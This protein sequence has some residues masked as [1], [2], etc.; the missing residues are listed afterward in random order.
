MLPLRPGIWD[1]FWVELGLSRD[2]ELLCLHPFVIVSTALTVDKVY[3]FYG[4]IIHECLSILWVGFLKSTFS[5][6]GHLMQSNNPSQH[7][8]HD[9]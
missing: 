4:M 6:A 9:R 3:L 5:F 8:C 2:P 7:G 1:K